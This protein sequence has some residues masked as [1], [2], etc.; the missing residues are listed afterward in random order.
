MNDGGLM[1]P[2]F[3]LL[4]RVELTDL[5]IEAD[6]WVGFSRH[7]VHAGRAPPMPGSTGPSSTLRCCAGDLG[8]TAVA[9]VAELSYRQLDWPPVAIPAAR[10]R[11]RTLRYCNSGREMSALPSRARSSV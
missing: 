4:P 3:A 11:L 7:F 8:I 1:V 2:F 10:F 5:L 6:G 9:D